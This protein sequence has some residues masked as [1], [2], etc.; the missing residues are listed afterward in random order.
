ML[1]HSGKD[2]KQPIGL[3]VPIYLNS[4]SIIILNS[5]GSDSFLAFIGPS[6]ISTL[7]EFLASNSTISLHTE[8]LKA[9][10]TSL[11]T[12]L[13]VFLIF[14]IDLVPCQNSGSVSI[15]QVIYQVMPVCLYW[16]ELEPYGEWNIKS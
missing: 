1:Y 7:T 8:F 5:S 10:T 16:H 15:Y 11:S 13:P 14:F 3:D 2:S 12:I 9:I 6:I 4:S